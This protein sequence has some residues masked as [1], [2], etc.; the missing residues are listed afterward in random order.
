M[1]KYVYHSTRT[2]QPI[3]FYKRTKNEPLTYEE[4]QKIFE[5][6]E[7][8]ITYDECLDITG[9]DKG[10]D[11]LEKTGVHPSRMFR[12]TLKEH[13]YTNEEIY[14]EQPFPKEEIKK[15]KNNSKYKKQAPYGIYFTYELKY[16]H[17][18]IYKRKLEK[19][20]VN[21]A[22]IPYW[23]KLEENMKGGNL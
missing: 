22:N 14:N 15:I 6:E 2:G 16:V 3:I 20:G 13:G 8:P 7:K 9:H 5:E 1:Y 21:V 18:S 23:D 11:I 12:Q 4:E 17:P 19:L 10:D